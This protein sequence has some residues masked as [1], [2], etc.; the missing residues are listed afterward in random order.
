MGIEDEC[1]SPLIKS[2]PWLCPAKTTE[3]VAVDFQTQ[4][5]GFF[6]I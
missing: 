1:S 3:N 6:L 4:E 5:Q 2:P